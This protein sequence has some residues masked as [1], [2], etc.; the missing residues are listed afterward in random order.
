MNNG[1]NNFIKLINKRIVILRFFITLLIVFLVAIIA[2]VIN[3]NKKND[4]LMNVLG[5]QQMLIQ[6]ISK[7]ANRKLIIMTALADEDLFESEERFNDKIDMLDEDIENSVNE[8]EANL[9]SIK[10]G[11]LIDNEKTLNLKK[12]LNKTYFDNSIDEIESINFSKSV[13]N[14]VNNNQINIQTKES[15]LFINTN[16]EELMAN[17]NEM[18][19][20]LLAHQKQVANLYFIVAIFIFLI[21]IIMIYVSFAQLNKYLIEPLN[22]LYNGIKSFGILKTS[23]NKSFSTKKEL[24]PVIDEINSMFDKLNKLIELISNLNKDVSFDGILHYIYSSFSEFIPY[25][26]IGIALLHDDEKIL[27]ASYGI[28]DPALNELPKRLAGIKAEISKT[29]LQNIIINGTPRV[30]NDLEKYTKNNDAEYNIVLKEAGIKSSITLPLKINQKPVGIIFFSSIYKNTYKQEHIAF[31]EILSDSISISLNK[32]I[33]IDELL[34]STLLA[35][36]KMAEAR[37]EDTGDHLDR[38]K[39]YSTKIAGFLLED[40]IYD[41]VITVNFIKD[42]E[43]F[44]PMHDIG[45][46]G[47]RDGIL[48]KPGQL[49]DEEFTEMKKHTAYGAE[50]LRIAEGNIKKQSYNMFKMGIEITENHHEKWNGTGYP[51]KKSG[52]NIPLSARIVAVADVLDAL[53][54]KRPYKRAF[55]FEESFKLIVEG[56]GNHF[57]PNIIDSLI[58]HKDEIYKLFMSFKN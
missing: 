23:K 26:H 1:E 3:N 50:V 35:L 13:R 9:K 22:E 57:D 52:S 33:F 14:I 45:K 32:N 37:D 25:S 19:Q 6:M 16:N 34:Y 2:F 12:S 55:P 49:T 18:L 8:Y 47:I 21:F 43:R 5:S 48:L 20:E 44:S 40:H 4:I 17:W 31:L 36:A 51:N 41:D 39:R 58:K 38:M 54:S 24:T 56:K 53:T 46:V 27:E 7:D 11:I 15:I 42:I 29:S 30:I 10:S 28:S